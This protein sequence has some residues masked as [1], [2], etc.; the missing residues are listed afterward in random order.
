VHYGLFDE[1]NRL[2]MRITFDHRAID[3]APVARALTEME[4]VLN[5]DIL[6]EI[7]QIPLANLAA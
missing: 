4:E 6:E 5:H 3:G 1:A 7:Q 2:D